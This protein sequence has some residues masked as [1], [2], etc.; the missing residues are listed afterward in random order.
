MI[1][2]TKK[3]IYLIG[4]NA[5]DISDCTLIALQKINDSN[6]LILS[7]KFSKNFIKSI[8]SKDKQILYE[9]DL[10]KINGESLWRII[11]ELLD[12]H[13]LISHLIDGDPFLDS[14][15]EDE[16]FFFN[17]MKIDC[18]VVP[19]IIKAVNCLNKNSKLLTDRNKNSSVT[20]MKPFDKNKFKKITNN[21]YFEKLLIFLG[22]KDEYKQMKLVLYKSKQK[23][24]FNL[25][26][27]IK[28]RLRK[29]NL[30]FN[31]KNPENLTFPTYII[32]ERYE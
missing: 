6:L 18:E 29:V 25:H 21:N 27:P 23:D 1:S 3:K 14:F 26:L 12:E 15:G 7:R 32:I 22:H 16:L 17:N 13:R 4:T 2:Q 5:Q 28:N 20:F 11:F 10:S 9:E 8:N 30:N 19:G 24:K 31:H